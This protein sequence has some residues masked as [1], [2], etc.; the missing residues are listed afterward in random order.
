MTIT[1][2]TFGY[3][4]DDVDMQ[5]ILYVDAALSGRRPGVLVY[6][7]GLGPGPNVHDRARRLAEAGYAAMV[8]DLHGGGQLCSDMTKIRSLLGELHNQPER[9]RARARGALEVL[10]ADDRINPERIAAIGHCFGGTMALE[11]A[12]SGAPLAAI[13]GFHSG[14]TTVAPQDAANIEGKVLVCIGA[15]DPYIPPEQR[16]AFE[17]E[18][19]AG[20]VDWTMHLYGGVVHSFTNPEA[21]AMGMPEVARYDA[22]ADRQSWDAM[23][24]LFSSVFHVG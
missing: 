1:G 16:S 23:M 9:T 18:M 17:A 6:P 3:R 7:E 5:A 20:H 24:A 4:A 13:V 10:T 21:A 15:D 11:L 8:C 22:A 19:R 14:L 2:Q 12:R